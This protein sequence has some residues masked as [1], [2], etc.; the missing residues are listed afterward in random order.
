MLKD[1]NRETGT[2]REHCSTGAAIRAQRTRHDD[3]NRFNCRPRADA[4]P[5][6]TLISPQRW[7][8][9]CSVV[10]NYGDAGVAWRLA[11]QLAA[12]YGRDTRLFVDAMPVLARIAP[13]VDP[14][15]ERQRARGVDV[16][17]WHG[18]GAPLPQTAPGDV[19][20]EAFGCGLP[21][22]VGFQPTG[23]RAIETVQS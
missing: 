18:A 20:I 14:S 12:E 4:F 3:D 8:I 11:R 2:C 1:S 16:V 17:R 21:S 9:F 19:V 10:D 15:R 5:L 23:I 13:D 6:P 7:D 22:S